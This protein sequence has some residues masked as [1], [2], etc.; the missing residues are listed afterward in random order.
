MPTADV[1]RYRA[2]L[3]SGR[4][5]GSRGRKRVA[6]R[7]GRRARRVPSTVYQWERGNRV[8]N[9]ARVLGYG[10]LLERLAVQAA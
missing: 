2:D 8:P 5:R 7:D 3:A 6:E 4:A 10:R 1:A 9:V